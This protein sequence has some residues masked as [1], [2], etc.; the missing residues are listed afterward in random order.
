MSCNTK[1]IKTGN[2]VITIAGGVALGA[3]AVAVV[4]AA[5]FEVLG[6][7]AV[8]GLTKVALKANEKLNKCNNPDHDH[9]HE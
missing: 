6:G 3:L 9:E 4:T 7:L 5:P 8:V 2:T 1:R